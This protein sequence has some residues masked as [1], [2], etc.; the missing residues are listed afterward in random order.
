MQYVLS[1]RVE[2]NGAPLETIELS[3]DGDG[4]CMGFH[5]WLNEDFE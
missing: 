1:A 4:L 5:R 2:R 3:P